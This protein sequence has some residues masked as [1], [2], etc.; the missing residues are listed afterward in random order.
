[1]IIRIDLVLEN[2]PNPFLDI[3][4]IETTFYLKMKGWTRNPFKIN[5]NQ[6]GRKEQTLHCP[7]SIDPSH[8]HHDVA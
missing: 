3:S 7:L 1:M 5:P 4:Q 8:I 2:G 6:E